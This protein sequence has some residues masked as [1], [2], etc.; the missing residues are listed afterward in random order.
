MKHLLIWLPNVSDVPNGSL[1][2]FIRR[3][4]GSQEET[5]QTLDEQERFSQLL[6]CPV[7]VRQGQRAGEMMELKIQHNGSKNAEI[8]ESE[9]NST[10]N[11]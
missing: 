2:R 7:S 10:V 8:N 5:R 6:F 9:V 1:S 3:A 4:G 11:Y